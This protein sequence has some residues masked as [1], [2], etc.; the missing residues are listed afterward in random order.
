MISRYG[1]I[2]FKQEEQLLVN[3]REKN[4]LFLG[5]WSIGDNGPEVQRIPEDFIFSVKAIH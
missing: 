2:I 4:K 3:K 1:E 5:V